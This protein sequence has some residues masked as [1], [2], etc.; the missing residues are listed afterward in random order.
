MLMMTQHATRTRFGD[1]PMALKSIVGFWLFYALTVAARAFL[2]TDPLTTLI[3]K[4][5]VIGFG[6]VITGV[7][8]LAIAGFGAGGSIRRKAVI[9]ALGSAV[10]A[11]IMGTGII[12]TEDLFRESREQ[13]RYQA[14]EG[15]TVVEQGQKIRIERTAQEP[16]VLTMPKVNELDSM[17]RV[18]FAA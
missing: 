7:I 3:N 16:L 15:F 4:L 13:F 17:K 6:I 11:I 12:L 18:R 2:G 9:A 10:G 5:V 8:Y 14:R 1:W